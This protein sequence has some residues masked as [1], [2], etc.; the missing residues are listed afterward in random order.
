[1]CH[2]DKLQRSC[3]S[4]PT[5]WCMSEKAASRAWMSGQFAVPARWC[6]TQDMSKQIERPIRLR[7]NIPQGKSIAPQN[8][9]LSN[10]YYRLKVRTCSSLVCTIRLESHFTAHTNGGTISLKALQDQRSKVFNKDLAVPVRHTF[11]KWKGFCLSLMGASETQDGSP[12]RY[13]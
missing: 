10:L 12:E 1:M 4:R 2:Y 11:S 9:L 6:R 3:N 13:C 5:S 8:Q 7:L